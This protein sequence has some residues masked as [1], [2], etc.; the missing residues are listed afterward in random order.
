MNSDATLY[1]YILI[2]IVSIA[3]VEILAFAI[4]KLKWLRFQ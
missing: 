2:A 3:V 4:R 1:D